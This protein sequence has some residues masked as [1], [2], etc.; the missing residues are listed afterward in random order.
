[1]RKSIFGAAIVGF[2]AMACQ[3]SSDENTH[4][5]A[6]S[7]DYAYSGTLPCA[8]CNSIFTQ[9]SFQKL[10]EGPLTVHVRKV[11][12]GTINGDIIEGEDIPAIIY[13]HDSLDYTILT[14][15]PEDS[16]LMEHYSIEDSVLIRLNE[17]KTELKGLLNYELVRE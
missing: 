13:P 6:S 12:K 10:A 8:D 17:N 3:P 7:L 15:F 14:L 2:S 11:F 9:I 4:P 5:L 1:M 16:V